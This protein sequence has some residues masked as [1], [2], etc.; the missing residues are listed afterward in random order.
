MTTTREAASS[1]ADRGAVAPHV[2]PWWIGWL[3]A[4]PVRR[5]VEDPGP[6]LEP[7]VR[8]GMT[9]LEP[10]CGM[11]FFTVPLARLVGSAGRVVC[12]DL[13]PKMIAGMERRARRAGVADRIEAVVG[14]LD[15]PRLTPRVASFDL[16]MTI[17][18]LH[19]VPDQGAFLQRIAALLRPGG[20]LLVV[21]PKGHVT[22]TA[23]A[24]TVALAEAAGLHSLPRPDGW[25]GH[26][27]LFERPAG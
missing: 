13:Q 14:T 5:L 1:S 16:A 27:A 2:C 24:A 11:G 23:F 9:A 25:R 20:R 3:L 4:S 12:V 6:L 21:E 10:G 22:A 18:M 26:A 8:P 15:D 7:L 17:H 19:E